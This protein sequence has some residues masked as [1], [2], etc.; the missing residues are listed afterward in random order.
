MNRQ[1]VV[2]VT[3]TYNEMGMIIDTKA[4][5]LDL[6]A[7]P[8]H[9]NTSNALKS[10]DC[11]DR[12]A[13]IDEIGRFI[14]YI[15]EDMIERIRIGLKRLPSAQ[16][17]QHG[18]VFNGIVVEY[19]TYST[20]P[21][22][23]GKPYFSIK[24]TENGQEFI[25]YGTYKPEVLSEYLKE[26]FMPSAQPEQRW[27]PVTEKLPEDEYVLISKKPTKL[28]GNKWCVT[29][30]IRMADPR[31]GKVQWRDSG[32]G[33]IQDDEVLAWMPRPKPYIGEGEADDSQC[34]N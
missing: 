7:Q 2:V 18:R 3:T 10:L 31:S 29:I 5:E 16:P 26:Y 14:G 34:I 22:Y 11:I 23:E 32:F 6:S 33:V 15:D 25:G 27:I 21:E 9:D 4:E 12:Q 20:Y 28:S 24:Y 13:A 19:P 17:E 8:T 30:A 1:R